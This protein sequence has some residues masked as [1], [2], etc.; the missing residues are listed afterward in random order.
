MNIATGA[1]ML[2]SRLWTVPITPTV[3]QA[4]ESLAESQGYKTLKLLGKNKT[5]LLP[6]DWDEDEE[7][8]FDD[9]YDSDD[10][11]DDNND[12]DNVDRFEEIDENEI[13]DL[14]DDVEN[15]EIENNEN[16]NEIE[17]Q[18]ENEIENVDQAGVPDE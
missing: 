12:D 5:R 7:Y 18:N 1:K 10:N 6:S 17:N 8:I 9:D 3:I 13:D 16:E 2:K 15:D 11:S 4:V 14:R